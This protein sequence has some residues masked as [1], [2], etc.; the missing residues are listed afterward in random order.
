MTYDLLNT[1]KDFFKDIKVV[2]DTY[3]LG[4][5]Y[6]YL[7]KKDG[8][9]QRMT[10]IKNIS[11][12]YELEK[13]FKIRD[14]Y[15]KYISSNKAIDTTYKEIIDKKEYTMLKKIFSNNIY[16]LF[17]KNKSVMGLCNKDADKDAVPV[18]VFQKG[19]D[20]YYESLKKLG[21][22]K[23][24]KGLLKN[25]YTDEEISKY[26][27]KMKK[28]FEDVYKDF[29][30]EEKPKEIEIKIFFE[31]DEKEYERVG[32]IY[33]TLKLFNTNENNI[34]LDKKT[35]GTNNYNYGL[36]SKKPFLELK[37]TPYKIGSMLST[38]EVTILNNI[39]IWLYNNGLKQNILKL[40]TDWEFNGIPQVE[41]E[42]QSSDMYMIKV[43]GNNG[44][45]KIDDYQYITKFSS[46]IRP[47]IC[48]DYIS[49][50]EKEFKTENIYGLE[51]YINNIWIANNKK[52]ER[53]YIRESYYDYDTKIAKSM[54]SNWKKEILKK[55]KNIF[56]D[57]F[58]KE[59]ETIFISKVDEIASEIL[60]NTMVDEFE[61]GKNYISNSVNSLNLW[62]ALKIYFDKKGE[63]E[64]KIN[65]IQEQC[66]QIVLKNEKIT[67]DEQYY[68][69]IGQV[70][71]YL[72]S[73]SKASKL[74]QDITS[75]FIK[76]NNIKRLKEELKILYEKYNYEIYLNNPKFNNI[77]S[78]LLLQEPDTNVKQNKDV[79]LAGI[80]SDNLFYNKE[81]VENG[82]NENGENE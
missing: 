46:K 25:G 39:Y 32:N 24:D 16:T 34:E 52:S 28:A 23:E 77:L 1:F 7:I 12:N 80:L 54:L 2:L 59:D 11:D 47:F 75:P 45:A 4:D 70:A 66:K 62:I 35:Y 19:I 56:L 8:T 65:N 40:P 55:Y 37:S 31:E 5:G 48:R 78:Q 15:S 72:L 10:I 67:T 3:K 68:Y 58:Q 76:A 53:N 57:V 81:K 33:F 38:E 44:V 18:E 73:K 51:W 41:E 74:T 49:N 13:Y 42:T 14:F 79:I 43:V 17:F 29:Y 20:K 61:Q 36:N 22:K 30:E 64:M 9:M 6:Y 63:K 69:L 21:T 71:Y 60:E 27:E 26:K 50:N 82:G